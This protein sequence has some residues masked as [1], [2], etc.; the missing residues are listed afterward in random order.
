MMT[1]ITQYSRA[2]PQHL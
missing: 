1:G 2:I